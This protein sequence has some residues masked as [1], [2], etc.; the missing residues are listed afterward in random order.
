MARFEKALLQDLEDIT[1]KELI[2]GYDGSFYYDEDP[3]PL[4]RYFSTLFVNMGDVTHTF[5]LK[6]KYTVEYY[7]KLKEMPE[8]FLKKVEEVIKQLG[9]LA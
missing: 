8:A 4:S 7:A 3:I 6:D 1:V 5:C 9:I 2:E